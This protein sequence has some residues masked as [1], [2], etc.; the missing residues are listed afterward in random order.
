MLRAASMVN[1]SL[2]ISNLLRIPATSSNLYF[3]MSSW[4]AL[5]SCMIACDVVPWCVILITMHSI[6]MCGGLSSSMLLNRRQSPGNILYAPTAQTHPGYV[7]CLVRQLTTVRCA[8]S[9]HV[10]IVGRLHIT[11]L[12]G[13]HVHGVGGEPAFCSSYSSCLL[14]R[15]H[16]SSR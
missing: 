6:L 8:T 15:S 11:Q 5:D 9:L 1:L 13:M 16:S 12:D 3:Q 7:P 4:R 10:R 2:D 14:T